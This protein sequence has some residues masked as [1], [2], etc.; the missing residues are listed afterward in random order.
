M[1]LKEAAQT[2]LDVQNACNASGILKTLAGPVLD[3]LNAERETRRVNTS[4]V[5]A[6][7]LY[8]LGELGG[9][10]ITSLSEG[11]AEAEAACKVLAAAVTCKAC[12]AGV[13]ELEVFPGPLCLACHAKKFDADA[14]ING[15]PKPDF[16]KVVSL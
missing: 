10:G 12:G 7:F 14:R 2:A 13:A 1:N 16:T 6:L 3:A 11:Y 4:P 9:W 8:K 15:L 5:I